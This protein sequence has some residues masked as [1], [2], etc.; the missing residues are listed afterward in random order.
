MAPAYASEMRPPSDTAYELRTVALGTLTNTGAR[1]AQG[2][3][4]RSAGK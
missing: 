2:A 1:T 4:W 3:P